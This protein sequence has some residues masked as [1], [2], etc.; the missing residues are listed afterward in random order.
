MVGPDRRRRDARGHGTVTSADREFGR[1]Q[2]Q[3]TKVVLSNSLEPGPDRLVITGD[4]ADELA[5]LKQQPGKDILLS[6]G[7]GTLAPLAMAPGLI[8]EYL[9]AVYPRWSARAR[10]SSK[11]SPTTSRSS[12]WTRWSSLGAL[13]CF[14][15]GLSRGSSQFPAT[16]SRAQLRSYRH[17]DADGP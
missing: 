13:C 17:G 3:L 15:I 16:T 6:C 11:A 8:D 2:H 4:I 5:A 9:L 1:L 14:G 7:P 10:D 12:S